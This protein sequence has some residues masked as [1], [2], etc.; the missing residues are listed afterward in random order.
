M[1]ARC[2][3]CQSS[4]VSSEELREFGKTDYLC[5]ECEEELVL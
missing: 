1:T 3:V 2:A 4:D 5:D